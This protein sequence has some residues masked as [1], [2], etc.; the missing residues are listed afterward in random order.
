MK[1][2]SL[3]EN[4]IKQY[5]EGQTEIHD[6]Y[7]F[8]QY[9]LVRRIV[10][11]MNQIYPKGKMDSQ[12]NYK[13]WFDIISPRIDTEVKNIDFDTA[14]IMLYSDSAVDSAKVILSNLY[15]KEWLRTTGQGEKINSVV[16][17]SSGWGNIVWKKVKG[18]YEQVD[19]KDFYVVN[20]TA[21]SLNDTPAIERHVMTQTQLRD[22][23]GIWE[24]VEEAIKGCA[25]KSRST[26]VTSGVGQEKE[27]PYYEVYE[28]NGEVS[29]KDL[30]EAR[31][32]SGGSEDEYVLAKIVTVGIRKGGGQV[33]LKYILYSDTISEMPYR[34]YHRG[35][36]QGR[37]FR[38][39]LYE[40]LMDC[41]TRANEIGNQIARGLEWSS[42]T[43]FRSSDKVIANNI[44]TDMN[45]GDIIRSNDIQHVPVRMEGLDQ[46]LADWNRI[47][48]V[49][50]SLA[51]SYEAVTGE[52]MPSGTPFRLGAMLNQN[53]NK[54]F[55]FLR[56]KLALSF[57][58]LLEDWVLPELLKDL[59]AESVMRITGDDKWV[60]RFYELLV[61]SWYNRNL[62][63]FGPHTEEEGQMIKEAQL[64]AVL[65]KKETMLTLERGFWGEFKPRAQIIITGE[66]VALTAELES[67]SN[68]IN[69]EADPVRRTALIE[70]A[71]KKKGIDIEN[72]PK[73]PPAPAP[74]P[75]A[76]PG[77]P[78][79]QTAG[80]MQ[81]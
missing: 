20:Q 35:R 63:S 9:K 48:E 69:L 60:R 57:T 39:G 53:A 74:M 75:E 41:Q 59:K 66:R 71:M 16:E 50:D 21:F 18:G 24:N 36:F 70:L 2:F 25:D 4:E 40:I 67:L 12:G 27:T 32:E 45:S 46:L 81:Q 8:S 51:N 56:E 38:T 14:D 47:I 15:L 44:L 19:L 30:Y 65:Q 29:T 5:V 10:L 17:D 76:Q 78:M 73:S 3:I 68:F 52:S 80:M 43:I 55:D 26:T 61:N 7:N 54:L 42:K 13:Y 49:A 22:K 11:Y 72:L 37:W 28:R 1:L 58:S 31:G 34:E 62:L 64:A 79:P 23:I 33:Q 77:Q 6:G